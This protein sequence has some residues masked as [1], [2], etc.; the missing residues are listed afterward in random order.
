MLSEQST[1]ICTLATPARMCRLLK[2]ELRKI[3]E[4][5][6]WFVLITWHIKRAQNR[7]RVG[8]GKEKALFKYILMRLIYD[9]MPCGLALVCV[10]VPMCVSARGKRGR[11]GKNIQISTR[12]IIKLEIASEART[13]EA[14]TQKW[15]VKMFFGIWK[16]PN[17]A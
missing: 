6:A 13:M 8:K 12:C 11:G 1:G 4:F 10:C 9:Y 17:W 16:L 5:V 14:N 2:S 3:Y 7:E 15:Q